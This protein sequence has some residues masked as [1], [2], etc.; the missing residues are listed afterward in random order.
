MTRGRTPAAVVTSVFSD[1]HSWNLVYLELLLSELGWRVTNLGPCTPDERIVTEC[2][3]SRPDLVVISSLNGHGVMDGITLIGALR[4][5]PEL[6][7]TPVVIGGNLDVKGGGSQ[8]EA[9]LLA[10]GFDAV[11]AGTGQLAAFRSFIR[12]IAAGR[13]AEEASIS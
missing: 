2:L 1:S 4:S 7:T 12:S 6:L 9:R 13:A 5:R 8:A 10:A 11:F 3:T